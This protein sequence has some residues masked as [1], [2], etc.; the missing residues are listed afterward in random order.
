[1]NAYKPSPVY[2][3]FGIH[4][5]LE[6]RTTA[7][8]GDVFSICP[9]ILCQPGNVTN[10]IVFKLYDMVSTVFQLSN[11]YSGGSLYTKEETR[12][13]FIF[14]LHLNKKIRKTSAHVCVTVSR[15]LT[16]NNLY[17]ETI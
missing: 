7:Y 13:D 3:V 12:N 8:R 11:T 10:K 14:K 2:Y 16:F 15:A 4:F 5:F 17:H 6:H 9:H 1:M